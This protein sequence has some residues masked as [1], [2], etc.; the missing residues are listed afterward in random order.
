MH[1]FGFLII[2]NQTYCIAIPDAS[3]QKKKEYVG[4]V[5]HVNT[6]LGLTT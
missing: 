2:D 3:T 5:L 6:P 1:V 4:D